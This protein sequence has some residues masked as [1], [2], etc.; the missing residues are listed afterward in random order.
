MA[1]GR[2]GAGYASA[3]SAMRPIAQHQ[4]ASSRAVAQLATEGRRL[5]R[6]DI[7]R[8][9]A[10]SLFTALAAWFSIRRGTSGLGAGLR[11]A[12]ALA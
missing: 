10:T 4:H 12:V 11:A 5:P 3:P 7:S 6:A 2:Q 9:L 8:R 1:M